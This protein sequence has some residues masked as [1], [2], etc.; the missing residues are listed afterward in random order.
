[1]T[2]TASAPPAAACSASATVS[3]VV[4]APQCTATWSVRGRREAELGHPPALLDGEKEA[5]AGRAHGEH[6]VQAGLGEKREV[7]LERLLVEGRTAVAKG[8]ERGCER[9]VDHGGNLKLRGMDALRVEREGHVL[10]VTLARPERRNAFDA[11]LIAELTEAFS[12]VGNARAVILAGEGPSFCAGADVEWQ[13]SSIDLSYE[14]NVED[15]MRLYRMC[16]VIDACPAPVVARVHGYALGGGSGLVACADVAV[17]AEDAVFGFSEV[18]LGI[19]PAVISPF[20]L[21]R[22]GPGAAR[23]WF[24]TGERFGAAWRFAWGSSTKSQPTPTR[25]WAGSWTPSRRRPRSGRAAKSLARDRPPGAKPPD[26]RGPANQR[27]GAGRSARVSREAGAAV[28]IRKLLV[29]N[30]GE[31][32]VRVF[33]TCEQLG[34]GTVAV[35]APDDRGSLHVRRAGEMVEIASYLDAGEHVRAAGQSGADAIHP[36]YGFLAE[37]ADFAAAVEAAGLTWVGPPPEVLSARGD[38]L[39]AKRIAA[40]AGVPVVPQGSA[41]EIGFPLVVKAAA[42]GGGRGMRV[43]HGPDELEE[44][45]AA[46]KREAEAA[47]GEDRVFCERY[48]ERPRHVEIQLLG[49]TDGTVVHLGER[50][51]SVQRRHQKVLEEAPSPALDPETRGR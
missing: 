17:A 15:A 11:A 31:I 42:G 10:R 46:A 25:R 9:T 50:D 6:P 19:I 48:V 24:L 34:I 41:D 47:F 22:I 7:R 39:E 30:R 18:H 44:A 43:V 5:L 45:V 36:G 2:A 8:R 13:R 23:R 26:R 1:M 14:E 3:A 40:E 51:C 29:A 4:C 12:D 38:K 16:E 33:A 28:G 35:A 49:D 27:G 21:A 20:V 32:A 37:N